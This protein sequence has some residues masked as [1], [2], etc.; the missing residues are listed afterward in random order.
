LAGPGLIP[1]NRATG[2]PPWLFTA[3]A[4]AGS[5]NAKFP[6]SPNTSIV[7]ISEVPP[8]EIIG[9]GMPVTGSNPTRTRC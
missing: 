2:P 1:R 6:S 9:N 8:A 3:A 4:A 7:V 5:R